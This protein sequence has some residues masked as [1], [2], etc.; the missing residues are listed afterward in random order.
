MIL[1][2]A[3]G[4]FRVP[5]QGG[6]ASPLLAGAGRARAPAFLPDGRR[7]VYWTTP[8]SAVWMGSLDSDQQIRLLTADS[9][10]IYAAGSLLYVRQGTLVAQ[11]FDAARGKLTGVAAPVA[12][13]VITPLNQSAA[14]SASQTGTLAYRTGML[15]VPTQLTWVDRRGKPLRTVGRPGRHLNPVLSPDGTRLAV[16]VTDLDRR[17]QDVWVMDLGRDTITRLTFDAHNDIYPAWSPDGAWIMFGSDRDGVFNLYQR[18]AN[19]TGGDEI[20]LKSPLDMVPYS[21]APDGS[22]VVYRTTGP[23]INL[24][25][26]PLVGPREPRPFLPSTFNVTTGMVSPDG[27]WLAYQSHQ[28]QEGIRQIYVQSFPAPEGGKWQ[29]SKDGGLHPRW[30]G[31]GRELFYY[32]LDGHLMAVS[33][34]TGA[35][36]ELGPPVPLFE[37]RLLNGTTTAYGYRQ[38]YDVARDGRALL[39]NLPVEDDSP[40]AITVVVNWAALGGE[41]RP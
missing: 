33:V 18:R 39:L 34:G 37:A 27:R 35:A 30:R 23:A 19:G 5:A 1:F 17:T 11:P 9:P 2:A 10:A 15:A 16:E 29:V 13:Q 21:W 7:F 14:F 28:S 24:G 20:V 40:A 12:E 22:A 3:G 31:D 41:L 4:L 36:I 38:Q 6:V 26:L 25:V 8:S 32:A